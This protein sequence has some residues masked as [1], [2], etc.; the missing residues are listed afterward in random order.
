V[1]DG[2]VWDGEMWDGEVWDERTAGVDG[3]V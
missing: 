1:W 3:H 2:E